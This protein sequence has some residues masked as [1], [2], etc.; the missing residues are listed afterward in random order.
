M[1]A[2]TGRGDFHFDPLLPLGPVSHVL[3]SLAH[4]RHARSPAKAHQLDQHRKHQQLLRRLDPLG[5]PHGPPVPS[6][7]RWLARFLILP[8][9]P[10][11]LS[12]T[13]PGSHLF[14]FL[15]LLRP[16]SARDNRLFSAL[17]PAAPALGC[18]SAAES[19]RGRIRLLCNPSAAASSPQ[20]FSGLGILPRSAGS[21]YPPP[22]VARRELPLSLLSF[23]PSISTLSTLHQSRSLQSLLF[24]FCCYRSAAS[25]IPTSTLSTLCSSSATLCHSR[26]TQPNPHCAVSTLSASSHQPECTDTSPSAPRQSCISVPRLGTARSGLRPQPEWPNPDLACQG[27]QR[28]FTSTSSTVRTTHIVTTTS[29]K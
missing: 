23:F 9:I 7:S 14:L 16:S 10:V 15:H 29:L 2:G 24:L 27:C 17:R 3:H 25:V 20:S 12:Q 22:L 21:S 28:S 18:S 19:A 13:S 5:I 6:L 26:F 11:P 4:L 8:P 1:S